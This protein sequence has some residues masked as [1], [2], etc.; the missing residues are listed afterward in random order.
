[1]PRN[2]KNQTS[3]KFLILFIAAISISVI[4]GTLKT[5]LGND[6]IVPLIN[7]DVMSFF[8]IFGTAFIIFILNDLFNGG[9]KR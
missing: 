1:M 9:K 7:L 4:S 5:T 6:Y 3:K 2:K 8:T